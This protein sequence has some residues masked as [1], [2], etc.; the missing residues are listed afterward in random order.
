MALARENGGNTLREK[1]D[2]NVQLSP[3]F[4]PVANVYANHLIIPRTDL[5]HKCHQRS[6]RTTLYTV[7]LNYTL[8]RPQTS[9]CI[10]R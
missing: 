1:S 3:L 8:I 5:I 6:I 9:P 2:G 7:L 4:A 10:R